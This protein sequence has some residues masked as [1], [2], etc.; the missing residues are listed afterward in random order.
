MTLKFTLLVAAVALSSA[1]QAEMFNG[2]YVGAQA[3]Y[4]NRSA[5]VV[6]AIPGIANFDNSVKGADYG[7]YAGYNSKLENNLVVGVEA[8]VGL[9]GKKLSQTLGL[10]YTATI[11]PS[12]NYALTAR[13]GFLASENALIYV[14]AGYASEK[15]KTDV[16]FNGV[17]QPTASSSGFSSGWTAGAGVEYGFSEQLSARLE[18]R[19]AKLKGSYNRSQVMVGVGYNF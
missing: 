5:K 3:G 19:Y 1:A 11:N 6:F 16:L 14:R 2:G 7:V 17:V 12:F 18:Y 15:L 9:S 8:E 10:G 13:V 4:A